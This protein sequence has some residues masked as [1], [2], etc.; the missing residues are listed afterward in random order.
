MVLVVVNRVVGYSAHFLRFIYLVDN[1]LGTAATGLCSKELKRLLLL[2]MVP[3]PPWL[4]CIIIKKSEVQFLLIRIE[5]SHPANSNQTVS[6]V[7]FRLV[8][9]Y[10][11]DCYCL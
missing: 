5:F 10:A 6:R 8:V 4:L 1:C 9:A 3:L 11:F 2:R 7:Y